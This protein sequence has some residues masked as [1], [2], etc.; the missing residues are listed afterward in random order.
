MRRSDLSAFK[1]QANNFDQ[2]PVVQVCEVV[3]GDPLNCRNQAVT[4]DAQRRDSGSA[5]AT[6]RRRRD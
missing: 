3:G 2:I 5:K 6:L 4:S 1:R